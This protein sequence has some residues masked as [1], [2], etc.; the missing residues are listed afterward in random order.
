MKIITIVIIALGTCF[1]LSAQ[2]IYTD[3]EGKVSFYSR[4][5]LEDI[6]AHTTQA[7]GIINLDKGSVGVSILIKSFSFKKALM[8]EHF[9]ENYLES[10]IYPKAV[11]NGKIMGYD[12]LDFK[13]AGGLETTVVGNIKLHGVTQAIHGT[14]S[15]KPDGKSFKCSTK[16]KLKPADFNIKIPDLVSNNIAKEVEV[17]AEFLI[18]KKD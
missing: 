6:E 17:T 9:N 10:D 13:R 4:T 18:S 11:F 7:L 2:N 3:K 16:F 12:T 5:P 15:F 1:D 14:V 8:E